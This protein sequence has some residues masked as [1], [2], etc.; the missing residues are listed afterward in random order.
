M[1]AGLLGTAV[2]RTSELCHEAGPVGLALSR[3]RHK[4]AS[5]GLD[6]LGR[7]LGHT[8]SELDEG[9]QVSDDGRVQRSTVR[10]ASPGAG[11]VQE[12]AG[13][14]LSPGDEQFAL[15]GH[16]QVALYTLSCHL[17]AFC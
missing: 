11:H 8:A 1:R 5:R 4:L 6:D 15:P 3:R 16:E 10:I 9:W 7:K 12:L 14:V 13:P 2:C 17:A